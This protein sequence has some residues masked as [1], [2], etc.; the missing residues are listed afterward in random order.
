MTPSSILNLEVLAKCTEAVAFGTVLQSALSF[1]E[2]H[3]IEDL[4][5]EVKSS[6]DKLLVD[7]EELCKHLDSIKE[8]FIAEIYER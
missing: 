6:F 2:E 8:N 1:R 7:F 4:S 5:E 3:G